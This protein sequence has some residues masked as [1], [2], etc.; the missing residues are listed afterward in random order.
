MR[1][2]LIVAAFVLSLSPLVFAQG[3][4]PELVKAELFVDAAEIRPGEAFTAFVKLTVADGWHIYWKNPGDSGQA[5]RVNWVLPEGFLAGKLM[6]PV[7][8][9]FRDG[10][11][12]N[13]GYDGTV[14]LMARITPGPD[15]GKL[16]DLSLGANVSWLRCSKDVCI[17]GRAKV[18]S[19]LPA[20]ADQRKIAEDLG[21]VWMPRIP[22]AAAAGSATV[23]GA[24]GTDLAGAFEITI[25]GLK[26]TKEPAWFPG[27]MPA[28]AIEKVR[29]SQEGDQVTVRFNARVLK[30]MKLPSMTLDSV[31]AY[32][33]PSGE[34]RGIVVSVPLMSGN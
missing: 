26:N 25:T 4:A 14:V 9:T 2:A 22:Q 32:S 7:P 11:L 28:L 34:R 13:F 10:E 17:P 31:L 18:Q 3:A 12:I 24:L 29:I 21:K 6:Y 19:A 15:A 5:T 23:A 33:D 1:N 20:S 30:G 27:A 16:K 8:T